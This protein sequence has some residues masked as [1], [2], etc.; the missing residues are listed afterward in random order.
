MGIPFI[1][2]K[3]ILGSDYLN[4]ENGLKVTQNPY[5]HNEIAVVQAI[6]PD[7]AIAHGFKG[8]QSGY[9]LIDKMTTSLLA[10][11][12]SKRTIISVEEIVSEDGLLPNHQQV[13]VQPIYVGALVHAPK[14]AYP[15]G[16]PGYYDRDDTQIQT[17]MKASKSQNTFD[18]YLRE[19]INSPL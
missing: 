19:F 10:I 3:G 13:L 11:Q 2:V 17:Y 15:T 8:T 5:D 9:A 4:I 12:A 6:R 1:P 16:C 18:V 7:V 14:G